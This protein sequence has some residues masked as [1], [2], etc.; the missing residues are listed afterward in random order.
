MDFLLTENARTTLAN[1]RIFLAVLFNRS[2]FI[3]RGIRNMF[4]Y[5][6]VA[7]VFG[8]EFR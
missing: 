1:N 4:N 7:A 6:H 8:I 2:H 3:N 5:N